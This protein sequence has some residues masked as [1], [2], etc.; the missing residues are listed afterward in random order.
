MTFKTILVHL[1]PSDRCAIRVAVAARLARA[2]GCHLVGLVPTGL[3]D[4]NIPAGAIATGITDFI[5]ESADYLQRRADAISDAFRSQIAGPV[6]LPFEI[7]RVDAPTVES[8]VHHGRSS[9]LIVLGQ[10]ERLNPADTLVHELAQQVMLRVGR[11]VLMVP[12][13]GYFEHIG[14][15]VLVAWDGSRESAV[16]MREALPLLAKAAH[17]SLLSFRSTDEAPTTEQ[18][19]VSE[20]T[21]WLLRHGVQAT[22]AQEVADTGIADALLSRTSDLG[23]DLIVMGGYGH[24][25]VRE[26]MLGGVTREILA[27]MTVPVLMAH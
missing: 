22:A 24:S 4:G 3:Y 27:H 12:Y 18:L 11:P 5:A 23:A 16:A 20:M 10:G 13:A 8:V 21:H 1:D 9:D 25:R 17:V 2:H 7:R 26:L 19:L 15:H 6:P 14:K